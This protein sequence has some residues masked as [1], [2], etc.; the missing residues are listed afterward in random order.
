[1]SDV[2][3]VPAVFRCPDHDNHE[4]ITARVY[5]QVDREAEWFTD[6]M[7]EVFRVAVVC[8][9]GAGESAPHRRVFDGTWS[10]AG[11][12]TRVA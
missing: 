7:R 11:A 6:R 3:L 2:T 5:E 1:M 4:L 9:G 10:R 12:A 8:P